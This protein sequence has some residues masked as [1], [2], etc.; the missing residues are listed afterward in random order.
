MTTALVASLSGPGALAG[1][2]RGVAGARG[3]SSPSGDESEGFASLLAHAGALPGRRGGQGRTPGAPATTMTTTSPTTGMALK[4]A[5]IGFAAGMGE[6]DTEDS[7]WT[8]RTTA[9]G[10]ADA[11]KRRNG[12]R[13]D[14]RAIA[15]ATTEKSRSDEDKQTSTSNAQPSPQQSW[16]FSLLTSSTIE[17]VDAVA[18]VPPGPL[19][20][21]TDHLRSLLPEGGRLLSA[22]AQQV[23]LELPHPT[24]P[25]LL[26]VS[27]RSGVVD[28]RARG[29]AASE[30]AWRVPELAAALQTAGVRLGAFEVAP[31][32]RAGDTTAADD[33][34]AG[35]RQ[36]SDDPRPRGRRSEPQDVVAGIASTFTTP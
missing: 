27:L 26:E 14:A 29:G 20:V 9:R 13:E 16:M 7:L 12:G 19:M 15:M 28:V 3:P 30:M 2:T 22:S 33:G 34:A 4:A 23:R 18:D 1:E 36:N 24:G 21:A 25:M 11:A 17:R 8:E 6:A 35:D 31:V 10:K 32:Q 5:G